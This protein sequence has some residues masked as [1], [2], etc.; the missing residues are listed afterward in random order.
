ME[1]ARRT[2]SPTG[3]LS[4]SATDLQHVSDGNTSTPNFGFESHTGV[5]GMTFFLE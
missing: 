1:W 4:T 2:V 5:A 3:R